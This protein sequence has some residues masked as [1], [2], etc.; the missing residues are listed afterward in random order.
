M[1][2]EETL[3]RNWQISY[4]FQYKKIPHA[5]TNEALMLLMKGIPGSQI[6]LYQLSI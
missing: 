6:D 1:G 4:V 5:T 3:K 2:I